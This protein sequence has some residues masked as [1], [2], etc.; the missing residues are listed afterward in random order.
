MTSE[1]TAGYGPAMELLDRLHLFSALDALAAGFLLLSWYG[2]GYWIEHSSPKNPSV[3]VLMERYRRDW[4]LQ[5][6]TRDPRVFDALTLSSLRQGTTFFASGCMIAIG[7][8]LA[9]IGNT[10]PLLNVAS[11]LSLQQTP[12]VVWEVKLIVVILLLS[13]G[14]LKF[15]W[16]Q[17]LFGYA[18]VLM[19]AVPNDSAD[20]MAYPRAAQ[21]AEINIIAA[22]NFNRGLR[23]V[24]FTLG[25]L[26]WLLGPLPLIA[27]TCV[28][29]FVVW[30]REFA[31]NSRKIILQGTGL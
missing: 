11:D 4:M 18:A 19:G 7:G 30:R 26:T 24:Y 2:I 13:N 9:L 20:P 10:D 1:I 27:A 17:R 15:V 31:S 21:A 22:R 8:V 3:T 25:S 23:A 28:T 16:S 5:H 14:F 6:V 12:K 29:F